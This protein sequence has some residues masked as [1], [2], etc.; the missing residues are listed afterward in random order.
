[1]EVA[2][3]NRTKSTGNSGKHIPYYFVA[4]FVF[5]AIAD[6]FFVYLATS[7]HT[8]VVKE[9]AY[10]KGLDYNSAIAAKE[11]QEALGW[12]SQL[13]YEKG[14]LRVVVSDAAGAPLTQAKVRAYFHRPTQDG[15]D[16]EQDLTEKENGIYRARIDFPLKGQWDITWVTQWKQHSYQKKTRIAVQ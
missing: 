4:F 2:M 14:E 9:Q 5:L 8:G 7:T 15:Y 16:F 12:E 13:A 1:M 3:K 6:G 11:T 10:E